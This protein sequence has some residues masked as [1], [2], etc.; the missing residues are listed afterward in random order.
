MSLFSR[1]PLSL[2][3]VLVHQPNP[4]HLPPAPQCGINRRPTQATP[5]DKAGTPAGGG[6]AGGALGDVR[7]AS[8]TRSGVEF[9]LTDLTVTAE[10]LEQVRPCRTL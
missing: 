2:S 9:V 8:D 3:N 1:T 6:A 5:G 10:R 4:L 7:Q